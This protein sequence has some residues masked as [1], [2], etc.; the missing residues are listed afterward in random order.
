MPWYA[1]PVSLCNHHVFQHTNLSTPLQY[2]NWKF[3]HIE[4]FVCFNCLDCQG[5]SRVELSTRTKHA[6]TR[7]KLALFAFL[8]FLP[9][10]GK[11]QTTAPWTLLKFKNLSSSL[12]WQLL[13]L[14][15]L[16]STTFLGYQLGCPRI[17]SADRS[18]VVSVRFHL[19]SSISLYLYLYLCPSTQS[20]M[21]AMSAIGA[22]PL[23]PSSEAPVNLVDTE[24]TCLLTSDHEDRSSSPDKMSYNPYYTSNNG[25]GSSAP[26]RTSGFGVAGEERAYQSPTAEGMF[27]M[28]PVGGGPNVNYGPT[29]FGVPPPSF[30]NGPRGRLN[31]FQNPNE[32]VLSAVNPGPVYATQ[33]QLQVAFGYGIRREDGSFTRLI[34]ADSLPPH[35]TAQLNLPARQGSEGLIIVAPPRQP[36]PNSRSGPIPSVS[37]DVSCIDILEHGNILIYNS[38][39]L[40]SPCTIPTVHSLLPP[41]LLESKYVLSISGYFKLRSNNFIGKHRRHRGTE[42]FANSSQH[43][44]LPPTPREGV[45]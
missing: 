38:W 28:S 7:L 20:T 11:C 41:F 32:V 18:W 43:T 30:N 34:P 45:L 37:R 1:T 31:S 4:V 16:H 36:S 23:T 25:E 27:P 10:N 14:L 9:A 29:P 40:V 5:G 2:F 17:L 39:S 22:E 42:R 21:S 19:L 3:A 35:L 15:L 6:S 24:M 13:L 12:L 33:E 8:P 44:R 26:R